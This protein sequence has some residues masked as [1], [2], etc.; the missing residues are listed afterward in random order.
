M[1]ETNNI[2]NLLE[3]LENNGTSKKSTRFVTGRV[4]TKCVPEVSDLAGVVLPPQARTLVRIILESELDEWTEAE[5]CDEIE[6]RGDELKTKQEPWKI[7][8]YYTKRLEE[9]GFIIKNK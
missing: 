4:Y 1:S 6:A 7:F 3:V 2:N 9:A 5:L 8:K